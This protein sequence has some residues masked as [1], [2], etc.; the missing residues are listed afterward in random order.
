MFIGSLLD[1]MSGADIKYSYTKRGLD[2][3][4]YPDVLGERDNKEAYGAEGELFGGF[5]GFGGASLLGGAVDIRISLGKE[6][7]LD[8]ICLSRGEN[9]ELGAIAV[10]AGGKPVG[11][12][13]PETG[14]GIKDKEIH[15]TIGV[16]CKEFVLRVNCVYSNMIFGQLKIYG[17][18]ELSEALYPLPL[19]VNA[20]EGFM[21]PCGI[22]ACGEDALF[23]AENFSE[24]YSKF[25]GK[26]LASDGG[27]IKFALSELCEDEY[28]ISVTESGAQI[29]GGSKRALL[30]A[31]DR[32]LE[33]CRKEGIKLAEIHDKPFM[34]MRG[35]HVAL[36]SV[37]D[38]PFLKRMIKYVFVPLGYNTVFLQLAGAM[39]YK[40]HPEI[41]K[42]W[43]EACKKYEAGEWPMPAHYHFVGHDILSHEQVK[44]LCSYIRSF[45]LSL[46]PEV[47]SLSHTQYITMAHP[48]LAEKEKREKTETDLYNEDER[49]SE[50]Y[51]HTMCPLHEKYYDIIFDIMDEVIEVTKP[52]EYVHIGHDEVYT[53]GKCEKCA[54]HPAAQL[55][56]DEVTA[57]YNHLRAKGLKTMMWSD[58]LTETSYETTPAIDMIP[59]DIVCLPFTWYFHFDEDTELPLAEKNMSFIIGNFYSSHY[60][61]FNKRKYTKGIFGAEISTWVDCNEASYIFEGKFYDIIYSANMMWNET[62]FEKMRKTYGELAQKRLERAM[63]EIHGDEAFCPKVTKIDFPKDSAALPCDI[64]ADFSGALR[65]ESGKD[66]EISVNMKADKLIFEQAT[67]LCGTRIPWEEMQNLGC[68][69]I[70]FED[71]S[72]SRADI[73]YGLNICEYNRDYAIPLKSPLFRHEGYIA[74]GGARPLRGKTERG[75]DYTFYG[76]EWRNPSPEKRIEKVILRRNSDSDIAV[77]LTNAYAENI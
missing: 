3:P 46:I 7:Y 26:K 19:E 4:L 53:I 60:P 14:K 49:P 51:Y 24:R 32:L 64:R 2:A 66:Y 69:E 38:I 44:E 18:S 21:K 70:F 56:A 13:E 40:S 62:H 54:S 36:P 31:A 20:K 71:G 73:F 48:E 16:C 1:K 6:F 43:L 59:K 12:Y 41:N 47:Q 29:Y 67:D 50:F 15:I 65:A 77:L 9:S 76:L 27:N 35:V 5:V 8:S 75:E 45:G 42:A 30:Y 39:E 57:L 28:K 72:R 25:F 68:Y 23:A 61:R 22:E 33:L 63:K 34:E 58:M 52:E 37:S 17:A 74:A 55:L 11:L 10:Y